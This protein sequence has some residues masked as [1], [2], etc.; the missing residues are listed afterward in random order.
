MRDRKVNDR[1]LLSMI[2]KVHHQMPRWII[3][4]LTLLIFAILAFHAASLLVI[5]LLSG[6]LAY[7]LSG[8]INKFESFGLK[9][10]AAVILLYLFSAVFLIMAETILSPYLQ[11]EIKNFYA[12]LPEFSEHLENI[13]AQRSQGN[14]GG[15]PLAEEL[16]R[17]MLS[18]VIRPS[19]IVNKALNI[20]GVFSQAASFLLGLVL[21]PFFVFFLLKDWPVMFKK[22]MHL[23]PPVHVETTVSVISEINILIGKYIRG[24][25]TDCFALSVIATA[26][27]WMMGVNYPISLGILTG[28]ANVIP[29]LGPV[30]A[31]SAACMIALIQSNSFSIIVNII[32]F[33][34]SIKLVDDL[35]IQPLTIGRTVK[36]HPML[37]VITII[38]GERLFGVIGMILAVPA[39]T[40]TQKVLSIL[41]ESRKQTLYREKTV[42]PNEIII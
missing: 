7:I 3:I 8:I 4:L 28:A 5:L 42:E 39:V 19:H 23:I 37:L 16:I 26:G 15:Y 18:D 25:T 10:D 9:R 30:M 1:V 17:K 21:V 36:L 31:C 41:I 35:V 40:I 6:L 13:I 22:V 38:I 12:K 27:L 29:Y 33:Y 2:E 14:I 32:L 20:S 24:L 34:I 11:Q